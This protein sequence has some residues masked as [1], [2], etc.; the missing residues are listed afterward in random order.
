MK[1]L[2]KVGFSMVELLVVLLIIGILAAV[3]APF[4]LGSTDK[5][6]ASEAVAAM[7]SIRSAERTYFS[8][9]NAYL[10]VTDGKTYFGTDTG[11][12]NSELGVS[13]HGEKY[14]SPEAYTVDTTATT[15]TDGTTVAQ[16]FLIKADGGA[17]ID[18]VANTKD[19]ARNADQVNVSGKELKVEMDNTGLAMYSADG[20]TTWNN[21]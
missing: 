11:N 2:N 13:V 4:F 8:Q 20:G 17:S 6:K 9:N 21:Y 5:A 19:G 18:L 1:K 15:F 7:G 16:D 3:A 10:A 12:K 14:F